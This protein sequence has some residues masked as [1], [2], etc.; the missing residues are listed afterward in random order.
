[1]SGI[2][3]SEETEDHFLSQCMGALAGAQ[4]LPLS[5]LLPALATCP[6]AQ[7]SALQWHRKCS[8]CTFTTTC[9]LQCLLVLGI[10]F[11][12]A[13]DSQVQSNLGYEVE[14]CPELTNTL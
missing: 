10:V 12:V 9:H 4:G 1:M 13:L 11:K 2:Y 14:T 7:C 8:L 3:G 6:G 5:Y